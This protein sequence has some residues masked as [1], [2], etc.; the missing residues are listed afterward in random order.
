[1]LLINSFKRR[2]VLTTF[3][4]LFSMFL[5]LI[6]DIKYG[7]DTMNF[8][9]LSSLDID[10]QN[11]NSGSDYIPS[12][13]RHIEQIFSL[14]IFNKNM[15]F[16]DIGSGKGRVL[17]IASQFFNK[18]RGVEFSKDLCKTCSKNISIYDNLK[19]KNLSSRISVINKDITDYSID[20]E[21]NVFYLFNPFDSTILEVFVRNLSESLKVNPRVCWIIYYYPVHYD[22]ILKSPFF[23][24]FR[25]EK[26][27]GISCL[28]FRGKFNV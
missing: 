22:V 2:G 8:T 1:M 11:K 25:K 4:V 13:A 17:L 5:D 7:T 28:I 23:K 26:L 12:R 20:K 27:D 24:L 14:D 15:N 16:T 19:N 21:E 10:S 3:K 6:F 18:I 9:N